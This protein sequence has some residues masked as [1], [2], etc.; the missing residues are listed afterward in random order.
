MSGPG[1]P[2]ASYIERAFTELRPIVGAVW[3]ELQTRRDWW[4]AVAFTGNSGAAVAWSLAYAYDVPI[5]LVRKDGE[6]SHSGRKVEGYCDAPRIAIVDDF[7]A[8]GGTVGNVITAVR[9]A[10]PDAVFP[11]LVLWRSYYTNEI[12]FVMQNG[13]LRAGGQV[14][15]VGID[16]DLSVDAEL[17][18][19]QGPGWRASR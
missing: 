11:L 17:P 7:V 6:R 15:V 3:R 19:L 13:W 9:Y 10:R 5:V 8:M 16:R 14:H 2:Y 4:D 18:A 1:Y 12:D